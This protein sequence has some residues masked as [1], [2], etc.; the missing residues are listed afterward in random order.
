MFFIGKKKKKKPVP[1]GEVHFIFRIA[2]LL[3]V[4][5]IVYRVYMSG[6]AVSNISED[7]S[8]T[9]INPQI[10]QQK[11][12]ENVEQAFEKMFNSPRFKQVKAFVD[13]IEK[14][15]STKYPK[16]LDAEDGYLIYLPKNVVN[17]NLAGE[18]LEVEGEEINVKMNLEKLDGK[19][20]E[21]D[22]KNEKEVSSGAAL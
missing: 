15:K 8:V 16:I 3:V 14:N 11:I 12:Q 10:T 7:L 18:L 22:S 1:N 6:G 20:A 21:E 5:F 4:V 9:N 13:Y 19:E 17:E 2:A